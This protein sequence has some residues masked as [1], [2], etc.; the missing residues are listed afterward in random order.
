MS[1]AATAGDL[2][3]KSLKLVRVANGMALALAAPFGVYLFAAP[4]MELG[5]LGLEVTPTSL[6]LMR[7]Y[8]TS[9]I[10]V[11]IVSYLG[12]VVLER[13]FLRGLATA[14]AIQDA[15]LCGAFVV[16]LQHGQLPPMAWL[17]VALYVSQVA[18]H[19]AVAVKL[20]P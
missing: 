11:A 18:L 5:M 13:R 12:L 19:T 7:M 14:N 3:A 1:Q 8:A 10:Q 15:L 20:R 4:Q 2:D 16:A 9:L 6:L 17:Y